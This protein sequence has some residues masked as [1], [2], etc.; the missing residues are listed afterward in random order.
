MPSFTLESGHRESHG[1]RLAYDLYL[2]EA[3]APSAAVL[4]L[5]GFG[6]DRKSLRGHAERLAASGCLLLA[7]DMSSLMSGG[8]EAAQRR[9]IAQAADGARFL[10]TQPSV[11]AA[12]LALT[13]IGHSAGGA[14]LFEAAAAL[15]SQGIAPRLV[16]L[17]DAVPWPRTVAL[18]VS[19]PCAAV[20]L[21]ALRCADGAWNMQ[22]AW[23]KVLAA[24]PEP[25]STALRLPL[26]KH[27]DPLLPQPRSWVSG[28]MGLRGAAG[29]V[30]LFSA[31]ID[32]FVADP[33][34]GRGLAALLAQHE[35]EGVLVLERRRAAASAA[36]A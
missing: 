27:G 10:L 13:L 16:L 9:N 33:E 29:S 8:T 5:H 14:V 2:P 32:A 25:F 20:P 15:V 36:P 21:V 4:L 28:L 30:E 1:S 11:V 6:A 12:G 34:G 7:P 17:L 35:K 24:L 26:S 18:A 23:D 3:A 31:L 22:G 19:W